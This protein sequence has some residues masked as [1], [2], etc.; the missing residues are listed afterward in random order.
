MSALQTR[1]RW[2]LVRCSNPDCTYEHVRECNHRLTMP[3]AFCHGTMV[4]IPLSLDVADGPVGG[5]FC[6]AEMRGTL[7]Y[8]VSKER[9]LV[10]APQHAGEAAAFHDGR[11]SA[12]SEALDMVGAILCDVDSSNPDSVGDPLRSD[13]EAS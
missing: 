8:A 6:L 4:R 7:E 11:A 13:I 1:K 12:F 10:S 3:C 9:L 2:E 5:R